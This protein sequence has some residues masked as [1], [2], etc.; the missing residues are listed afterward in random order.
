MISFITQGERDLIWRNRRLFKGSNYYIKEDLPQE[1][2]SNAKE[3]IPVY[4]EALK[5]K[6]KA[7]M[8]RDQLFIEG[9]RYN[10]DN[11]DSLTPD[12]H[13]SRL[14]NK[15]NNDVHFFWGKILVS[16][17]FSHVI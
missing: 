9:K 16:P 15:E 4:K 5:M 11:L 17:T 6:K 2:E 8:V 3:L 13:P 1:V 12:L 7:Y 14:A 10:Q